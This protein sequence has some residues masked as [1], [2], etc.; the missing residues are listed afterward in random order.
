MIA[1][2]L[3]AVGSLVF[4]SVLLVRETQMAVAILSEQTESLRFR[5]AHRDQGP[6]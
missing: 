1:A 5:A 3:V 4:G 6:G 2:G